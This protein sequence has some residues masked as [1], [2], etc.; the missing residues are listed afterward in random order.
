MHRPGQT[1]E[2]FV[3]HLWVEGTIEEIIE[4]KLEEKQLLYDTVIDSLSQ[5]VK[6]EVLFDIY[7]DLLAKHGIRSLRRE[8]RKVEKEEVDFA[9]KGTGL[10]DCHDPEEFERLASRLFEAMGYS[11]R[12]TPR[13][14][15][16]G[17]DVIGV[18]EVGH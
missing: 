11:T 3:Y 14:N 13:S 10:T 7:E 15:D 18:R 1:K 6:N 17:V 16:R 8:R 4:R 5:Q 2:V 12:L 9:T